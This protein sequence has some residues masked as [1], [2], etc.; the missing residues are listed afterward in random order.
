MPDT[1][2][3][4]NTSLA[5]VGTHAGLQKASEFFVDRALNAIVDGGKKMSGNTKVLLGTV[6]TRYL[7]NA[8]ERYNQVHTIATGNIVRSILGPDN[9]YVSIGVKYGKKKINTHTV[10][11]MLS[12]SKNLLVEGT[13]GIGKSMMMRYLFLNSANRGEYVPVLLELRKISKQTPGLISIMDLIYTCMKDFD[14]ELPREQFEF[15]LRMGKYLFLMDGFDEVKESMA[16]E[17]AEKIQQFC[18]KYPNNP[19]IITTRPGRNTAPLET[20]TTV[21][22][23][24]L[25]KEQAVELAKKIRDEDDK[26]REFCRQLRD[27]LYDEPKHREFAE[28][29]L[30]L[31]MM[32]L[33]FMRNNSLPSHLAEFYRRAFEAL[34]S[35]HDSKNKGTYRREFKCDKLDEPGFRRILSHFCFQ[36]YFKQDYEF[37]EEKLLLYLQ[38]SISKFDIIDV[39]PCD[40]FKDLKNV[41]CLL[42][43]DGE[44]FKFSHRSF[45]TYFAAC[46][47]AERL[48]DEE[49]KRVLYEYVLTRVWS[50]S[51]SDDYLEMLNQISCERFVVNLLEDTIRSAMDKVNSSERPEYAYVELLLPSKVGVAKRTSHFGGVVNSAVWERDAF[52]KHEMLF[53]RYAMRSYSK[54]KSNL[55]L[56]L[57]SHELQVSD[58]IID[59]LSLDDENRISI[60]ELIR[61]GVSADAKEKLYEKMVS[62]L[63]VAD[64]ISDMSNWLESIDNQRKTL[65]QKS[66]I[67]D[68]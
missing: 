65:E 12:V 43:R 25:T 38:K 13:G 39:Q 26:T 51:G 17:T 3:Q 58:E 20:F 16:V 56:M 53:Y 60:V 67:E 6:F 42:V 36:S 63:K 10:E 54:S 47:T 48:N 59:S 24:P 14:A 61:L 27:E 5:T 40:F 49:Q 8:T 21:T 44:N 7:K 55:I 33:T 32:F 41:I 22:S 19:C 37:S 64:T 9:I 57:L 31:S 62:E 35:T 18:S 2:V 68:L 66:F 11:P 34:Y 52:D 1:E 23:L 50:G 4:E 46:Y 15:S 30:L 45:Q 28:N 29:P